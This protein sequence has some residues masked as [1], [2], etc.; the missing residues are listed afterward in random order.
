MPLRD[1]NPIEIDTFNGL[2]ARGEYDACPQDHFTDCLNVDYSAQAVLSRKP[3]TKFIN[4]S[5]GQTTRSFIFNTSSGGTPSTYIIYFFVS[6]VWSVQILP[7]QGKPV[8]IAS[9]I[10]PITDIDFVNIN[11]RA[12]IT[13]SYKYQGLAPSF[14]TLVYDGVINGGLARPAGCPPPLIGTFE[15]AGTATAGQVSIGYHA[16]GVC[17][18]TDTGFLSNYVYAALVASP[19]VSAPINMDGAHSITLTNI[20]VSLNLFGQAKVVARRILVSQAIPNW[21]PATAQPSGIPNIIGVQLFFLPGGRIADNTTTTVTINFLDAQLTQDASYLGTDTYQ[22]GI[23]G[24][25]PAGLAVGTYHNRLV[26]MA[27]NGTPS[28]MLLSNVNDF[29]TISRANNIINVDPIR[30]TQIVLADGSE[31]LTGLTEA[32]EYRDT[33]YTMKLN[34]TYAITDNGGFPSSWPVIVLDE[35]IGAFPKGIIT[36][37]DS[38]GVNIDYFITADQ[39]GMYIFNGLYQK[40]EITWKIADL[41]KKL[42][43][44]PDLN[45]AMRSVMNFGN[46]TVNKKIYITLDFLNTLGPTQ[47]LLVDYSN[48]NPEDPSL[49]QNVRFGLWQGD[50]NFG[51]SSLCI[52]NMGNAVNLIVSNLVDGNFYLYGGTGIAMPIPTPFF[53]TALLGDSEY[54]VSHFGAL[55]VRAIGDGIGGPI[56]PVL[57]NED[58]TNFVALSPMIINP[59]EGKVVTVLSNFNAQRAI[60]RIY[61][62]TNGG[63]FNIQRVILYVKELYTSLPG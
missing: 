56:Y 43:K 14:Y 15:I 54:D 22:D 59:Q 18:E 42:N 25:V 3:F 57:Y 20:P 49:Y 28:N 62:P 53:Q 9:F 50:G 52:W 51:A 10:N 45:N 44:T 40:P 46:D 31:I 5:G 24:L 16:V 30:N 17:F 48:T 38:G 2:W 4:G 8:L 37:L 41:W 61:T 26:I 58:L 23:Y 19:G 55:R 21:N 1:H 13:P 12:Y 33:L 47:I 34:K 27:P 32:Q 6:E 11:G 36:V 35:G 7:M 63:Y 29:E 39:T 60:L